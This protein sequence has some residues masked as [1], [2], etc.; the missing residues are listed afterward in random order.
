MVLTSTSYMMVVQM[1][2]LVAAVLK[3]EQQL[4]EEDIIMLFSARGA[5]FELVCAAAGTAAYSCSRKE[6]AMHC[7]TEDE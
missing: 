6:V 5:D 2:N 4:S 3:E 1:S 7:S